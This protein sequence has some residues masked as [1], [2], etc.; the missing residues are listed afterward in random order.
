MKTKMSKLIL[1]SLGLFFMVYLCFD[2]YT[3]SKQ[4]NESRMIGIYW[5]AFDPP[6]EAHRAIILASLKTIPLKKIFVIVNNHPY[7]VYDYSLE[8]RL[9]MIKQIMPMNR[10]N[11]EILWQDDINKL[12]YPALRKRIEGPL[13]AIA[14]YDAYK[15][16]LDFSKP[17]ER[18]LYD[19]IAVIPRGDEPPILF[20]DNAF[21]LPIDAAYKN[22]SSTKVRENSSYQIIY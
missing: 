21:L 16:W 7:K 1:L 5:G 17:E 15:A 20:D 2:V 4:K 10:E 3:N 18:A 11:I 13:C 19:A 14:G 6:T 12:N 22:V 9:H 8:V